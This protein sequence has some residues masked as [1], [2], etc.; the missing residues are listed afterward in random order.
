[1][2]HLP[3][4]VVDWDLSQ[5]ELGI[6]SFRSFMHASGAKFEP[7]PDLQKI[8]EAWRKGRENQR[9]SPKVMFEE[10]M[11]REGDKSLLASGDARRLFREVGEVRRW[12][13]L[14][15]EQAQSAKA[16][17]MKLE[18]AGAP[19]RRALWTFATI[20][21]ALGTYYAADHVLRQQGVDENIA[22][23][24]ALGAWFIVRQILD[25]TVLKPR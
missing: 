7:T 5:A 24:F 4:Y 22:F 20:P 17:G 12:R 25:R 11:M 3:S 1:M 8:L 9:Y 18:A 19:F 6:E 23:L 10:A 15:P 13:L 16:N 21:V 14:T 2:E